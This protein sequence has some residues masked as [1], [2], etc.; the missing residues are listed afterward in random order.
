MD[1]VL[2]KRQNILDNI[3]KVENVNGIL[4]NNVVKK[5]YNF[6]LYYLSELTI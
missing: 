6:Q 3:V 4:Q 1:G 2:I 5:E